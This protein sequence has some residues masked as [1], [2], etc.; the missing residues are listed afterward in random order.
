MHPVTSNRGTTDLDRKRAAEKSRTSNLILL[1]LPKREWDAILSSLELVRFKPH[2]ILHEAG[3]SIKSGYFLNDGL[4]SVLTV[5]PGEKSVE[6]GLVGKE[7][8]VGLP[9]IFG[10]KTS[11]S[12]IVTRAE[13][14][15]FCI[16]LTT[17][18]KILPHC[19]ELGRELVRSSIITD[20]QSLQLAACNRLHDVQQ[21]LARW[22]LMSHDRIGGK[23]LV[24]TQEVLGQMLGTRRAGVNRAASVLQKAGMIANTRGNV[25]I[26]NKEKLAEAACDCYERIKRQTKRWRAETAPIT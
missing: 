3:E 13:G 21:R 18:N 2:Q 23:T 22:L 12:R 26:L 1:S 25:V 24:F 8:F 5:L 17:L 4:C 11:A 16:D 20:M 15:A 14:A 19:P 6:V 7:A 10:F 9:G